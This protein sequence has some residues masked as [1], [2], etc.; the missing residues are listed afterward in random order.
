MRRRG[1]GCE[2]RWDLGFHSLTIGLTR[3][4]DSNIDNPYIKT[5]S[6]RTKA[7][8]AAVARRAGV[9]IVTAPRALNAHPLVANATRDR[10]QAAQAEL[11]YTPNLLARGLVQNRTATVGVVIPELANPFFVP[12]VSGIESVAADRR[13][14]TIVGESRRQEAE[15]RLYVEQFR[16]FLIGGIIASPTTRRLDMRCPLASR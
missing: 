7:T 2:S 13:F 6:H 4:G 10:I 9:S 3:G 12:M 14:L 1:S 11:G 5:L 8:L 16:Q 15:E